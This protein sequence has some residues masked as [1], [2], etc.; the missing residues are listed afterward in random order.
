MRIGRPHERRYLHGPGQIGGFEIGIWRD[1]GEAGTEEGL[2]LD[3]LE[4][5]GC[6]SDVS[7]KGSRSTG[8]MEIYETS[9]LGSGQLQPQSGMDGSI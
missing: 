6:L 5:L 8:E 9:F 4:G 1:D 3:D 7:R 2:I